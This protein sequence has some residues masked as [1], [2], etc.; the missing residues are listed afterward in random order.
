MNINPA[1]RGSILDKE[2]AVFPSAVWRPLSRLG[3]LL[4]MISLGLGLLAQ[5]LGP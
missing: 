3:L 2:Q 4:V 1:L 5:T